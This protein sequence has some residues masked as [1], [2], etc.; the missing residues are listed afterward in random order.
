MTRIRNAREGDREAVVSI[1]IRTIRASYTS[2]LGEEA[3]ERW[4]A[5]CNVEA[6]STRIGRAAG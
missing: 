5:E 4:L 2:F 3:V 1:S 6:F